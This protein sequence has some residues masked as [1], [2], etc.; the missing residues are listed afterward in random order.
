MSDQYYNNYIKYGWGSSLYGKRENSEDTF[1]YKFGS[2]T[3]PP[4][5]WRSECVRAAD[6]IYQSTDKEILIYFSGGIDSEIVCRS[7]IEAGHPFKVRICKFKNDLNK[8]DIDYAIKFCKEHNVDYSFFDLDIEEYLNTDCYHYRHVKY[9]N[10]YWHRNLQKM[11][12]DNGYGFQIIGDGDAK[13]SHD[14]LNI[15][16]QCYKNGFHFPGCAIRPSAWNTE[17]RLDDDI[18]LMIYEVEMEVSSYMEENNID[19]C[20]LFFNYTPELTYSY[21][22]DDLIDDWLTYCKLEVLPK[23]RLYPYGGEYLSV[24]DYKK[25]GHMGGGNCIMR[26]KKN[27]K[28]KYWPELEPRPK[29]AGLELIQP[30][31]S[32]YVDEISIKQPFDTPGNNVITIPYDKLMKDLKGDIE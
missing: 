11:F 23:D 20:H 21:L 18:Y 12:L 17:R 27:I 2:C 22:L 10:P 14:L 1:W 31:I 32:R 6:L 13:L 8:H 24:E 26:F 30:L 15:K 25:V 4:M 7:F 3:Q 16:K 9:P 29:Y 5:D 28:Y 19:G